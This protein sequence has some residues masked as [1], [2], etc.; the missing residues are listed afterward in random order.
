ML[1]LP[2]RAEDWFFEVPACT[3]EIHGALL[4][5]KGQLT[6]DEPRQLGDLENATGCTVMYHG[7]SRGTRLK[8]GAHDMGCLAR[9]DGANSRVKS[10]VPQL[11]DEDFRGE[12]LI[13]KKGVYVETSSHVMQLDGKGGN[14]EKALITTWPNLSS[15]PAKFTNLV[16]QGG[17][18]GGTENDI[19]WCQALDLLRKVLGSD[20]HIRQ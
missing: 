19:G 18:V 5:R 14:T 20:G 11:G 7:G 9:A 12:I 4:A 17:R 1:R 8:I 10:S 16:D 6:G 3:S 2:Q 15:S 13:R